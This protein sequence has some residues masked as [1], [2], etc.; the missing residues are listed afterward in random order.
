MDEVVR[1][2]AIVTGHVQGVGF[3]AFTRHH[4]TQKKLQGW[5]RNRANGTVELEAEG[6]RNVLEAFL[7]IL[8][9]GPQYSR[10][11]QISVDWKDANRQTQGFVILRD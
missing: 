11:S 4:A 3:R 10:V 9:E 6:P 5:V 8:H 1:I 7:S 2:H